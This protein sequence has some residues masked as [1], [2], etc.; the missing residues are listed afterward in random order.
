[1]WLN[2][3]RIVSR[4]NYISIGFKSYS[5]NPRLARKETRKSKVRQQTKV[6]SSPS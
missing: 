5:K 4:L 6:G 3:V 1:V 2:I